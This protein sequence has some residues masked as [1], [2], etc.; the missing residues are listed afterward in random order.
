MD[1]P[2]PPDAFAELRFYS[3][4]FMDLALW[5]PFVRQVAVRHGFAIRGILPGFPGTYPTFI[6]ELD[7]LPG[8]PGLD[9]IV[10]KF[11]GQLFDGQNSFHIER[12]MGHYL[13]QHPMNIGSPAILAEGQLT[14]QWSYLIFEHVP[15][16]SIGQVRS[17]LSMRE[18]EAVARQ[19]GRF[20]QQLHLLTATSLPIIP[21]LSM[22]WSAY[23][24]FLETQTAN[25]WLN[26]QRWRDLPPQ[27]LKLLPKFIP[28]V[29]QLLDFSSSPHIIH[30]DLTAD[31]LLGR[32]S[33][34]LPAFNI[35]A[36]ESAVP[37]TSSNE[38]KEGASAEWESLAIIDWGDSQVGNIL[39]ELVG[40]HLDLFQGDKHLLRLCL[41]TY[42]LP[43]FYQPD[44]ARKA[45]SMVL[46]HQFP[47]PARIYAPH[48]QVT[49]LEELSECLF[50]L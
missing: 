14:P 43:A 29:D 16:V 10:I 19:M 17:S 38:E 21:Q 15:G 9:T 45:L 22:S 20:M 12:A 39:Y 49:T 4:H 3:A 28:P 26:H 23:A 48:Q 6:A 31:H 13:A 27:L 18:M 34:P 8:Q 36:E 2:H 32:L 37:A 5:R 44:F 46:L 42:E 35:Q 11:F 47:M 25:C 1:H 41:E 50:G 40:L 33:P 30:A 7:H 24:D